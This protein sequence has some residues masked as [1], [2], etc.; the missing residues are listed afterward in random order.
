M[1]KKLEFHFFGS[2]LLLLVVGGL[3]A[4]VTNNVI[5]K[6][7]NKTKVKLINQVKSANTKLKEEK[8]NE[9]LGKCWFKKN[10][11]QKKKTAEYIFL[12]KKTGLIFIL[13]L[14]DTK[15]YFWQCFVS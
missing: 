10:D 1:K 9:R 7:T 13:N 5:I 2:L 12:E 15:K 3:I 14:E 4:T 6:N 8:W 11:I